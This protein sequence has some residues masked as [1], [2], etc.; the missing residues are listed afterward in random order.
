M[1]LISLVGLMAAF[2]T[3]ASFI[4]QAV[5]TI[6]TKQTNGLSLGMYL[7]LTM[8]LS[9]WLTYGIFI[10]DLPIIL[11]NSITLAFSIIILVLIMKYR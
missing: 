5:K 3:T 6:R 10:K 1:E 9:L 8:G 2:C 4:P 11:A 7:I